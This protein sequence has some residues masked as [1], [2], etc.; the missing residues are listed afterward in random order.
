MSIKEIIKDFKSALSPF[1]E[2]RELQNITSI[3]F[4]DIFHVTNLEKE[5]AF[6]KEEKD[7]VGEIVHRLKE[8]EPIAYITG[9]VNFFGYDFMVNKN[10]LIPRPETEELVHWISSD[11]T[12]KKQLDVLDVGTGSGCIPITLKKKHA[13]LRVFGVEFSLDALNV[14]RINGR[15]LGVPMELFRLDFLDKGYWHLLGVFDIIVS[16]PPYIPFE[17]VE[18]ISLSTL[19]YEPEI[20]LFVE[21]DD[22][23]VFY[24]RII[25]FSK[26]HLQDT[27]CIY[28]EVNEF[29]AD[30]TQLLFR[31]AFVHVELKDDLQGKPRMI[32]A[33]TKKVL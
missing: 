6:T 8:G 17:E 23:L 7:Q 5:R 22:P 27:G 11:L 14:A 16:N 13:T 2:E 9:K 28:V 26:D 19:K 20:A 4:E 29:L 32:K 33:Y 21:N 18:K 12:S 3:I 31:T 10:V 15:K 30:I 24:K 1:Y 25:E